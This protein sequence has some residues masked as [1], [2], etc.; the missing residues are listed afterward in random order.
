[1]T[2]RTDIATQTEGRAVVPSVDNSAGMLAMIANAASDPAVDAAKMVTLADLAMRL[3]D[4]ERETE[5]NRDKVRAVAVMP[6]IMQKG[7]GNHDI[8]YAKF[9]DLHRLVRPVLDEHNLQITFDIGSTDKGWV[10]VTPILSHTNGMTERGSAM[11]GPPDTGGSK[12]PVQ[13]VA[14]TASYLKRHSMKAMLNVVEGGDDD[15][16]AGS[17]AAPVMSARERSLIAEAEK[18][19]EQGPTAY[20]EWFK[21]QETSAKGWLVFVGQHERLKAEAMENGHG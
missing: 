8:K 9:E 11:V 2:D 3:Q 21:G 10:S 13:A 7:R 19:A 6:T 1:M 14:S 12:S 5:F 4:R 20:T 17:V 16:G 15:D 18:A